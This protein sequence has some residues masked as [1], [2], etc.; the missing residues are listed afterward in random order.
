MH[1][2]S[3]SADLP[4]VQAVEVI[5]RDVGD[6][7]GSIIRRLPA[8]ILLRPSAFGCN[9]RQCV[10]PPQPEQRLKLSRF[11]RYTGWYFRTP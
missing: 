1:Q 9:D 5:D 2:P 8:A 6:Q 11:P 7:T 10:T 4:L 3:P